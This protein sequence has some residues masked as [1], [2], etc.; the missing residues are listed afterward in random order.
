MEISSPEA[1]KGI[2]QGWNGCEH[3]SDLGSRGGA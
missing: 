2:D 1:T 3:S